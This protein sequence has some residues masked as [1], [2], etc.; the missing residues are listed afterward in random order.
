MP[1]RR[2]CGRAPVERERT[3]PT[4]PFRRHSH[5]DERVSAGARVPARIALLWIRGQRVVREHAWR[6]TDRCAEW[7]PAALRKDLEGFATTGHAH[8]GAGG[9]DAALGPSQPTALNH[10]GGPVAA[11]TASTDAALTPIMR[12]GRWSSQ[13]NVSSARGSSHRRDRPSRLERAFWTRA[14]GDPSGGMRSKRGGGGMVLGMSQP[15]R[16]HHKRRWAIF[17]SVSTIIAAL[18]T[19]G[20]AFRGS[21][22]SSSPSTTASN[23]ATSGVSVCNGT[24]ITG[25]D[26]RVTCRPNV[27]GNAGGPQI[28]LKGQSIPVTC[29]PEGES[30]VRQAQ[31]TLEVHVWCSE[32]LGLRNLVQTKVKVWAS[33]AATGNLDV[34]LQ[35]WFLLIPGS[36]AA[37]EWSPPPGKRWARP[38]VIQLPRGSV[39]AIPANPN[40]D[41]EVLGPIPGGVNYSFATHWQKEYLAPNET[42]RPPLLDVNGQRYT[43][44]T[45][46]F[47][48]PLRRHGG[49]LYEPQIYGLARMRD[50]KILTLCPVGRWGK[51]VSAEKF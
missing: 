26:N 40:N 37:R 32:L 27:F 50:G 18:V 6:L 14:A 1:L 25:S 21:D 12:P 42:W 39:T 48:V 43:D 24:T 9:C 33:N 49:N 2:V 4:E 29:R 38:S 28:D 31:A 44:G 34:S 13:A 23:G 3:P 11:A 5:C 22:S 45:L 36:R 35:R 15:R 16:G 47:Y 30:V 17:A 46:V 51:R 20:V 7:F 19:A 10:Q 8:D 41:A